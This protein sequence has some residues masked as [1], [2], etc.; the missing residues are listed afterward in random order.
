M[1]TK[2]WVN[3]FDLFPKW[4]RF[5]YSYFEKIRLIVIKQI[6]MALYNTTLVEQTD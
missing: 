5:Y 2:I 4:W 1:Y 6:M 3:V